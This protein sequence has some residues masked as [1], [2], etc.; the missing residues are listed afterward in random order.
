MPED[1]FMHENF[2]FQGG[3]AKVED[4]QR[5]GQE[6]D[7]AEYQCK[8]NKQ[9]LAKCLFDMNNEILCS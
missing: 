5:Q 9:G 4:G 7:D 1:V 3:L 2:F 6:D 8:R